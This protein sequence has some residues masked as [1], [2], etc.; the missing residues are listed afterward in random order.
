MT[1]PVL[2]VGAGLGGICLAYTLEKKNSILFKPFE[3]NE[4]R[5]FRAQGYRIRVTNYAIDVRIERGRTARA[6]HSR[7]SSRILTLVPL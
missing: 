2:I 3:Q 1:S 7:D 5:T 6:F 4:K